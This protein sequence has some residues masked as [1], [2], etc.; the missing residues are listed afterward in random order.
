MSV[1]LVEPRIA[2]RVAVSQRAVYFAGG[3]F[4]P[5]FLEKLEAAALPGQRPTDFGLPAGRSVLD[6]AAALYRDARKMW[7]VFRHRLERLSEKESGTSETRNA[8]VIPF[9][10]LLGYDLHYNSRAYVVGDMAYHISHRAGEKEDAPPVHIV[11]ARKELGR[12]DPDGRPRMS[13]HALMQEFL[14]R[15]EHLWGIVTNGRVLRLLRKSP[16]LRQQ[17]YVEFDLEA[18]FEAE[19]D[20]H[21]NDFVVLYRLLHRTRPPQGIADAAECRLELYYQQ[22][23]EEGNRAR[24]RLRDGVEASLQVLGTGFLGL[25]SEL[26]YQDGDLARGLYEDLL[27]LVY[28]LLF[29]LVAEERNLLGGTD[30]YR[31]HYSIT[32]LRRLADRREAYTDHEDLWLSLRVL[33]ELLRDP[34]PKADGR[35]LAALLCLPVLD[36]GL[37]APIAL[38]NLRLTNRDL[39]EAIYYLSYYY[40]EES[41]AWRRVNYAALDVEELGSVYESLLDHHPIIVQEPEGPAFR[42]ATGTERKSTGSYYTPPELVQELIK[43]TLE[44]VIE[45]RLKG[46]SDRIA[47]EKALLSIKVVD[48]ACGSGHFLLAAAR[49]LARELARMRTVEEEPS[50]EAEREARREVIAYCIYGVDKNPL[51][52]EL[53]KVALW[54]EG[55]VP[56]K[57][58]TFLDHRIRCGDSLVGVFDLSV[59]KEG[60]PDA[61]YAPV[62]DDDRPLAREIKKRNAVERSGQLAVSARLLDE[63]LFECALATLEVEA[64]PD[65]SPQAIAEKSRRY[66]ALRAS[67]EPIRQACDLWTAAFFQH[68]MSGKN[69]VTT[70]A[71]RRALAGRPVHGQVSGMAEA[72]ARRLRFFHWPLEFQEVFAEGGFDVVLCNPPYGY[73]FTARS[74]KFAK[75][76]CMYLQARSSKNMA[77]YFV[78][79]ALNIVRSDGRIGFVMPKSFTYSD[80]WREMRRYMLPYIISVIDV[81]QAW[82]QVR[83]EQIML[84]LQLS[85]G[86][87]IVPQIKVGRITGDGHFNTHFVHREKCKELD[88]IPSGVSPRD[89]ELL[90]IIETSEHCMLSDIC[91]TKRGASIKRNLIKPSGDIPIVQGRNIR[92]F[93]EPTPSGFIRLEDIDKASLFVTPSST[94]LF[95]NIVAHIKYP[96]EHIRI[97]GTICSSPVVCTD[98]VNIL[99]VTLV[100][101]DPFIITGYLMSNLINWYVHVFIFNRAQRTMHFDGYVLAR[102]PIPL[103]KLGSLSEVCV[104]LQQEPNGKELWDALNS[105]VYSAFEIPMR[106]RQYVDS[107]HKPRY[108]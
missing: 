43:S 40:D 103:D 44:P 4:G 20:A 9:L 13:P 57:P 80:A 71:V 34:T 98:T 67:Q 82:K 81:G 83:L 47:Q 27:R 60:I 100:G 64:L 76:Q 18:I 54:I 68:L 65:D 105:I 28:R 66:E 78:L 33:W 38:E 3:L 48:P 52:V 94:P 86:T 12:V 56:G 49:R 42:F 107:I 11:A 24:D 6:E 17:A 93:Q 19:G 29:L 37:F 62:S 2:F 58:L 102:I 75:A 77:S 88:V 31:D 50:P 51:A 23:L 85:K 7:Q 53:C 74:A 55:H 8:W 87:S 46:S 91:T 89:L 73:L 10:S 14:N 72:V 97:I 99:T 30:L 96:Q 32:R 69:A 84:T 15:S 1:V 90:E 5:D 61:A 39:L 63:A 45:E 22:A 21:F 101:I 41:L 104:G 36:G 59:L 108:R 70:D 95:Q 25:N 26:P 16:L 92:E 35:P 106:L 79:L